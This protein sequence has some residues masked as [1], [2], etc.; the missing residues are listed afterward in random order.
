MPIITFIL[1]EPQDDRNVGSV[2]RAL[3]TMGHSELRLVR[4]ECD[5]LSERARALAHGSHEILENSRVYEN[6]ELATFDCDLVVAAT[7]RHRKQVYHYYDAK[8]VPG[9]IAGMGRKVEKI[10]V[11][12]GK[13]SNGLSN[14]DIAYCDIV[15]T[16]AQKNVY[17]SLNLSQA[18]MIYSYLLASPE[19][20]IQT[21]DRRIDQRKVQREEYAALIS[22]WK[23][24]AEL[25]G[26]SVDMKNKV[27]KRIATLSL[28]DLHILLGIK[29]TLMRFLKEKNG[30][31]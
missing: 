20:V 23:Y 18:V 9:I 17:P 16:I 28:S 7:A 15:S 3:L 26:V 2:A 29:S 10:A 1:I 24:L 21:K 25:S 12:F 6:I 11:V 13:E 14:D 4:P 19:I 27:C 5:P 22:G 8:D 30:N 31:K